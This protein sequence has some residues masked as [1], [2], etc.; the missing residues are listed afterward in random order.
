MNPLLILPILLLLFAALPAQASAIFSITVNTTS[1]N[2]TVGHVDL[3][4]GAANNSPD[5]SAFV[6]MWSSNGTLTGS[7]AISGTVNGG[8][9][10]ADLRMQT[11][12][13]VGVDYFHDFTFGTTLQFLL[14]LQFDQNPTGFTTD[15][16]FGLAFYANDGMTPLIVNPMLTPFEG[17]DLFII[18][19]HP[20]G[21][22]TVRNASPH[23]EA[24]VQS[25]QS[26]PEPATAGLCASALL[27]GCAA[28]SFRRLA[29]I[30]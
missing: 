16:S 15:D 30:P 29:T 21:T 28:L 2:T 8:P 20:D 22:T 10:P 26:V 11:I 1:I 27:L 23:N 5:A 6:T 14:T 25:V 19:L 17:D 9:L 4:F 3:Q 13:G 7:P 18:D 12:S 24:M